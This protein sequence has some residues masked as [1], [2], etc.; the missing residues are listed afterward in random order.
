MAPPRRPDVRQRLLDGTVEFLLDHG[1]RG[2]SLMSLADVL[3]TSPRMLLYHFASKEALIDE[4]IESARARQLDRLGRWLAP[5]DGVLYPIV[6]MRAWRHLEGEEMQR[7]NRLFSE[8]AGLSRQPGSR[9]AAF[10]ARTVHDWLPTAIDGFRRDG[11]D[12]TE[13]EVGA[14]LALALMRGLLM[15]LTATGDRKRVRRAVAQ[16]GS[17]LPATSE[18]CVLSAVRSAEAAQ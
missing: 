8:L 12:E 3:G 15:D 1:V 2:F 11:L 16:L 9:F 13:A 5:R 10:G 18:A 6:L 7:F 17:L 14:T 4:A